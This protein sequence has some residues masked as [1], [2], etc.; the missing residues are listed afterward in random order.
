[1]TRKEELLDTLRRSFDGEAW[2][3]PALKD[4]LADVSADEATW[5]PA[6][7]VHSI[8]E[9]TLHATGWAREV[10]SRL[11]GG[12]SKEPAG[13]DWPEPASGKAAAGW[14]RAVQQLFKAR[15]EVLHAARQLSDDDFDAMHGTV[16]N[17]ALGT[18]F[19]SAGL[20]EGAAQHNAYHGG[21]MAL[22]KKMVRAQ[23]PKV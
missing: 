22:L 20:I 4:V 16:I 15:D 14:Q 21:Q 1:M 18:G 8:W 10:A 7:G 12:E 19:S 3:G 17:S 2:H 11:N 23:K 9:I 6:P 5:R 13:G